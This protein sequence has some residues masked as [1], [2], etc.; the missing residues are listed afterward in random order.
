MQRIIRQDLSPDLSAPALDH[1]ARCGMRVAASTV[2]RYIDTWN[3]GL[4]QAPDV[5][6][7]RWGILT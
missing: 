3:D 2:S 6:A 7:D 4:P 5:T 1:P